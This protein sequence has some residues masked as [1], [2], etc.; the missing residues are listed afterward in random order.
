MKRI[1]YYIVIVSMVFGL[2]N[3]VMAHEESKMGGN[4]KDMSKM[5]TLPKPNEISKA[6]FP[7]VVKTGDYDLLTI[8]LDFPTGSG[9][10]PHSHGGYVLATVLE[11]EMTLQ[12]KGAE[13]KV[14]AGESWTE[15]P[16]DVHSVIN[17]GTVNTRVVVAMLLP[18]GS[19]ATTMSDGGK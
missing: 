5:E 3:F 14:K 8:V 18:K 10:L 6:S 4:E 11:G 9:F 12:D 2:S 17:Q 19:S 13:R 1:M 16:G 15:N 7:L